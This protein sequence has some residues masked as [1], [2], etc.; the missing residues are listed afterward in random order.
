MNKEHLEKGVDVQNTPEENN[1]QRYLNMGGIINEKDYGSAMAKAKETIEINE[2]QR[3]QAENIA[4]HAGIELTHPE[5]TLDKKL[6]L[7]GVLQSIKPKEIGRSDFRFFKETLRML[8]DTNALNKLKTTY[9][10]NRPLGT[11]CP[12]CNQTRDSENCP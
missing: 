12:L 3:I 11:Y 2:T 6:I 9:H 10:T 4:E 1:Y 8:E 7:Y 5:G